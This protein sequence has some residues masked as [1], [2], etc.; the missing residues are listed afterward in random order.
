PY[1]M[2]VRWRDW[3]TEWL[4]HMARI[5][6]GAAARLA[7]V[8]EMKRSG[9]WTLPYHPFDAEEQLERGLVTPLQAMPG[10]IAARCASAGQGGEATPKRLSASLTRSKY[11]V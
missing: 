3:L 6:A 4:D 5:D 10:R 11:L 1:Q 8:V 9:E 7:E 2:R